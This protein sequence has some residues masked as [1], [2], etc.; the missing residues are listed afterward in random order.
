MG[1]DF[2]ENDASRVYE[3]YSGRSEDELFSELIRATNEQKQA[4]TFDMDGLSELESALSP[5]LSDEQKK[6]LDRLLSVLR[7]NS[8]E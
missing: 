1:K 5:M 7:G 2:N 4:G 6:K 3:Q 8:L